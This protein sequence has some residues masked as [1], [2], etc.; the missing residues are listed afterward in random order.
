[1]FRFAKIYAP[2]RLKITL[3]CCIILLNRKT[4]ATSEQASGEEPSRRLTQPV[5]GPPVC[6]HTF[7]PAAFFAD[8]RDKTNFE[9]SNAL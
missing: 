3:R 4:L 7:F 9:G 8:D 5:I 2:H 6:L 1:M